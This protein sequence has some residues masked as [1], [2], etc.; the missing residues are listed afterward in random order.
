MNKTIVYALV[1]LML[2][3]VTYA[4]TNVRDIQHL[5]EKSQEQGIDLPSDITVQISNT[6]ENIYRLFMHLSL[7]KSLDEQYKGSVPETMSSPYLFEMLKLTEPFEGIIVNTQE[8]DIA[9]AK[10]SFNKFSD[11]YDKISQLVPEWRRYWDRALVDKLGKDLNKDKVAVGTIMQ[12][13]K[14]IGAT[15]DR[16]HG[17]EWPQVWAKYYWKDF[18][19]VNVNT[20]MG[21]MAWPDAMQVKATGFDGIPV[22]LKEGKRKEAYKSW[23]LY[24]T[25][26]LNFK[27]ACNNCH[28]TPRYY[29]VSD[30]VLAKVD[31]M[32][33][34]IAGN[35]AIDTIIREQQQLGDNCYRCHIIHQPAQRMKD[36]MKK[37][38]R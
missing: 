34:D 11:E 8:G 36:K 31:K 23:Q 35:V 33:E 14:A 4:E 32:G 29:F 38:E 18:D 5:D 37:D 25:M 22:N 1:L 20:P 7:P 27:K 28:T 19:T 10:N 17:N 9:N 16:C 26:L 13:V 24:K 2:V 12:D 15:C 30:D 21:N 3:G 6:L